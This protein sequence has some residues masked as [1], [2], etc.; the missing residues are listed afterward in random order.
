MKKTMQTA[1]LVCASL[2][3]SLSLVACGAAGD[4]VAPGELRQGVFSIVWADAPPA[5]T[6]AQAPPRYT[7]MEDGGRVSEL[8]LGAE[9]QAQAL[10]LFGQRVQVE[11]S[12]EPTAAA[13]EGLP[14]R[15]LQ[16]VGG[17]AQAQSAPRV[18]GS[19]RYI[20]LLCRFADKAAEPRPKA[21][22]DGL[23]G[24]AY[25]GLDHYWRQASYN[26]VNLA[27]STTAGWFRLPRARSAYVPAG[28][29]ADL[30]ALAR[31]CLAAADKAVNFANYDGIN[32]MFN[33][34]LDCCAWGGG[35]SFTLDGGSRFYATT[36]MPPW[37][38]SNQ[39][40][41]AHEEGHS[42][43]LPHSSNSLG[44]VYENVWDVMSGAWASCGKTQSPTLGCLGQDTIGYHKDRLGWIP[45][46]RKVVVKAG[47]RKTIQLDDLGQAAGS[48]A[49]LVQVP[50]SGSTTRF[51]TVEV[52]RRAGYDAKL[53][54]DA[55]VIH[56]VDTGRAEP[57][58]VADADG[59]GKTDDAG[60][61]WGVGETYTDP[62]KRVQVTVQART[63]TGFT[64]V[65]TSA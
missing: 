48:G 12:A 1:G 8:R 17:E 52:R 35:S 6:E 43:G 37:G 42:L 41:M 49:L 51:V 50:L 5:G 30:Q 21:Y 25:P 18:A 33:D 22:Y 4:D 34:N 57:A 64:V 26:Q 3:L 27:G 36:W 44:K 47:E 31:D 40:V 45:A 46:A 13:G 59:N 15:S 11:L 39:S 62:S 60:A 24:G 53:P 28:K 32:F 54:G 61:M 55:V 38:W 16:P 23:L 10:P 20:N 29:S 58:W 63:P 2:S 14:V 56:T 19:R 7:L 65:V 9:A